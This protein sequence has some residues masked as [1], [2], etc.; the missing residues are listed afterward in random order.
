VPDATATPTATPAPAQTDFPVIVTNTFDGVISVHASDLDGDGD[1]DVIGAA[2]NTNT[3]SWWENTDAAGTSWTEHVLD[4]AFLNA[5]AVYAADVDGDGD[6]D[7]LGASGQ[8]N[9]IV[10]WENSGTSWNRRL[11]D[12]GFNGAHDVTSADMDGDGDLDVVGAALNEDEIAWWENLAG[13]GSSWTKHVVGSNF[14]GTRGV[15][16]A[17]MDGDGDQDVVGAAEFSNQVAWWENTNGS[18]TAWTQYVVSTTFDKAI[19]VQT[20][21]VDGDG[22]QDILGAGSRGGIAWWANTDGAGTSWTEHRVDDQLSGAWGVDAADMDGDGDLDIL[23]AGVWHDVVAWWENTDGTGTSWQEVNA[24]GESGL[25]GAVAVD[26]ADLNGDGAADVL[27][28]G[29]F[30]DMIQWQLN[31][32]DTGGAGN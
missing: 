12:G 6:Q 21:D 24:A 26:A 14:D 8:A 18:G 1:Q 4:T 9:E 16:V 13:D 28:G 15:A 25:D 19:K 20:A 5:R 31:T 7:V 17:D 30:A 11:I 29:H 3:V 23:G 10:W 2:R 27:A 32:W 22:D